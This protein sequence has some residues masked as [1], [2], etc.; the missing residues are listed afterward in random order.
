MQQAE[1]FNIQ[2]IIDFI[3]QGE[4]QSNYIKYDEC[5]PTYK[6]FHIF[7]NQISHYSSKCYVNRRFV[8]ENLV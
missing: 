2:L 6:G 3:I 4:Y 8:K 1:N 7:A 5:W